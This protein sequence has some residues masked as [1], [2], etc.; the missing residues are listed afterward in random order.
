MIEKENNEEKNSQTNLTF[1]FLREFQRTCQNQNTDLSELSSEN[2]Q[3][4]DENH[5]DIDVSKFS[6]PIY[7]E[8]SYQNSRLRQQNYNYFIHLNIKNLTHQKDQMEASWKQRHDQEKNDHHVALHAQE[9]H[10]RRLERK[11]KDL[12]KQLAQKNQVPPASYDYQRY[13][14][15]EQHHQPQQYDDHR[16]RR[17]QNEPRRRPFREASPPRQPRR[18]PP[19]MKQIHSNRQPTE[20]DINANYRPQYHQKSSSSTRRK[21][22]AKKKKKKQRS[23]SY[24]QQYEEEDR[25]RERRYRT[26]RR[27]STSSNTRSR[28]IK[29]QKKPTKNHER[30]HRPAPKKDKTAAE[31]EK[32]ESRQQMERKYKEEQQEKT[33]KEEQRQNEE[34]IRISEVKDQQAFLNEGDE[35]SV[36]EEEPESTK[37]AADRNSRSRS[38]SVQQTSRKRPLPTNQTNQPPTKRMR[39][40]AEYEQRYKAEQNAFELNAN[41]LVT[42]LL[43]E[44]HEEA[45]FLPSYF[46]GFKPAGGVYHFQGE[47]YELKGVELLEVLEK[48]T[49][50]HTDFFQRENKKFLESAR[51]CE[52]FENKY[53]VVWTRPEGILR[54]FQSPEWAH[55]FQLKC[56]MKIFPAKVTNET[57]NFFERETLNES[58]LLNPPFLDYHKPLSDDFK[59]PLRNFVKKTVELAIISGKVQVIMFPR[60]KTMPKWFNELLTNPFITP[61]NFRRPVI[62]L[63][64]EERELYGVAKYKLVLLIVGIFSPT[65]IVVDNNVLGNFRVKVK[66][67]EGLKNL[68]KA[69]ALSIKNSYLSSFMFESFRFQTNMDKIYNRN[70]LSFSE[71]SLEQNF[72]KY[73]LANRKVNQTQL[74][75][76][77]QCRKNEFLEKRYK[78]IPK[79]K[80]RLSYAQHNVP[81]KLNHTP[82]ISNLCTYCG[83]SQHSK[84]QCML[85]PATNHQV[86]AKEDAPTCRYIND[87][88]PLIIHAPGPTYPT[89]T[90]LNQISDKIDQYAKKIQTEAPPADY[91]IGVT[92]ARSRNF[93]HQQMAHGKTSQNAKNCFKGF[94]LKNT[95]GPGKV[96]YMKVRAKSPKPEVALKM[97]EKVNEL[98]DE[99]KIFRAREENCCA[100]TS[101]FLLEGFNGVGKWKQRLIHDFSHFQDFYKPISFRL[102]TADE[103][104]TKFHGKICISVDLKAAF[105]QTLVEFPNELAFELFNPITGKWEVY[106]SASPLFGHQCSP[107][108]CHLHFHFLIDFFERLNFLASVYIDDFVIA[109]A[110]VDEELSDED[111]NARIKFI[112]D[113]F[114]KNGIQVSPKMKIIPSTFFLYTGKKFHT[115]AGI[116][117][118]NNLKMKPLIEQINVAIEKE[119]ITI[120]LL[121]SL[122]GKLFWL[123]S[124][125]RNEFSYNFNNVISDTRKKLEGNNLTED[126]MYKQ[127]YQTKVPFTTDIYMMFV[128]FFQAIN[129]SYNPKEHE[130]ETSFEGILTVDA[131]T[132]TGGAA[133]IDKDGYLNKKTFSITNE[134]KKFDVDHSTLRELIALEKAFTL[135]FQKLKTNKGEKTKRFLVLN[136]NSTTVQ[137]LFHTFP[138]DIQIKNEYINYR[139]LIAATNSKFDFKWTPREDIYARLAD[140]LSKKTNPSFDKGKLKAIIWK[141]NREL[142]KQ[143]FIFLTDPDKIQRLLPE[144]LH[145][146]K[147]FDRHYVIIFPPFL[148]VSTFLQIITTLKWLKLSFSLLIPAFRVKYIKTTFRKIFPEGEIINSTQAH[149]F[150]DFPFSQDRFKFILLNKE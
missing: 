91:P 121:D 20:H 18:R 108:I 24:H 45:V 112:V 109:V 135:F 147:K 49:N 144:N 58:L 76:A 75:F 32:T 136:D 79:S 142:R 124:A 35:S 88:E 105:F 34:R 71:F 54:S 107:Y 36:S 25:E 10:N 77:R 1:K 127:L 146:F 139:K 48:A 145:K 39:R 52:S 115:M 2:C 5:T 9:A 11:M 111:L 140:A 138:K 126:E 149:L 64:G 23:E 17:N 130:N 57:M 72:E 50:L 122:R 44:L 42:T 128:C 6:S 133:L 15:N 131:S 82:F 53:S 94:R 31:T 68:L 114:T 46:D 16:R 28:S 40:E 99:N 123:S 85:H 148:E 106:A 90:E 80:R 81:K 47:I 37:T 8:N 143:N 60:Y 120:K 56:G 14:G 27:R 93:W 33:R 59:Q 62:F 89:T 55:L 102:P 78:K 69:P 74:L 73:S 141:H 101:C 87:L 116:V 113:T 30:K 103:I 29:A 61:V 3:S 134:L 86:A 92:F 117:L 84:H 70:S 63:R 110:D 21:R 95:L 125:H 118:P 83:D 65:E 12:Q 104:S 51:I 38:S 26:S 119:T 41:Q 43:G 67:L 129:Q 97:L 96:P 13:Q 19:P 4:T 7:T 137:H 66:Q 132:L 22:D 98:L 150:I 100:I